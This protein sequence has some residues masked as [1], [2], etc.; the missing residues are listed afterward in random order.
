MK[1]KYVDSLPETIK[2]GYLTNEQLNTLESE[3]PRHELREVLGHMVY[4]DWT[5]AVAF[6]I[7]GDKN[8]YVKPEQMEFEAHATLAQI[9][10][11]YKNIEKESDESSGSE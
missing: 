6:R 9:K 5:K 1:S 3:L 8:A 4:M 11:A 10:Y 7:E 2:E